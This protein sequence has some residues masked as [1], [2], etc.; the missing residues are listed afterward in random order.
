[1]QQ[2]TK[3]S[4]AKG[5]AAPFLLPGCEMLVP[6]SDSGQPCAFEARC[7]HEG[8]SPVDDSALN[9]RALNGSLR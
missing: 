2:A 6:W 5:E 9:G 3:R 8:Q 1:M 7:P 4:L